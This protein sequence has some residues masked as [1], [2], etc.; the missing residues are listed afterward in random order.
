MSTAAG[1]P[2]ARPSPALVHVVPR[3]PPAL[4]GVGSYAAALAR[5]LAAAAGIDGRFVVADPG[6]WEA[7][8]RGKGSELCIIPTLAGTDDSQT[9]IRL[10]GFHLCPRT[11]QI[12][13]PL[14]RV[15]SAE[16]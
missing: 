8:L 14:L 1:A 3:L 7:E 6:P 4:D 2:L 11:Q 13:Q 10:G 9:P 5:G 12:I 15:N 16:R